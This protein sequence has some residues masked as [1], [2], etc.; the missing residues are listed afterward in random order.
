MIMQT[1]YKELLT[2]GISYDMARA[3]A[4]V[5]SFDFETI[6]NPDETRVWL[7]GAVNIHNEYFEYG[8][9]IDSFI[10]KYNKLD[11]KGYFHNLKFDIQFIFYWLLHHG[12]KHTAERRPRKGYFTTL[13][14][15]MGVFYSCQI[16]FFEGGTLTLYDSLRLMPMAV[17]D[18]PKA[19]GL[20]I[21]KLSIEYEAVRDI[22]HTP[23]KEEIDYVHHDCLIVARALNAMHQR[24]M[25]KLTAA[26]NA[27]N[28]FK[29]LFDKEEW[30]RL[31][32]QLPLS[33]DKDCRRAYKGGWTYLNPDY[34]DKILTTG[35][36]YDVNSMYPWAMSYTM[37]PWG[38]PVF[39]NG[40]YEEDKQMPLFI[41]CLSCR[42]KLKPGKYPSIQVKGSFRFLDTEYLVDSG[43][44][45]V[46]LYLTSVDYK[47]MMDNYE[48]W[49]I[50]YICGY[51]FRGMTGLF[52]EYVNYWYEQKN[53]SKHEKNYA[54]YY[55]AK[56]MLNSLYG[57]FGSNPEKRSKYPYLDEEEDIVKYE[58]GPVETGKTA[59]VPIAAFITSYCR[60]KII[61]TAIACGE[62]F[63]YA[64]TDSVHIIG[65]ETPDIDIDEYRLGAFKEE[66]TFDTAKFHRAKCYIEEINGEQEKKCAGLPAKARES[67]T[68]ETMEVGSVFKGKLVPKNIKGGVVL[69]ER[70]F[71]IK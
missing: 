61:R 58:Y 59:Y 46:L 29:K 11:C 16:K 66:S 4:P 17:A 7:W 40:K 43:E 25:T 5:Y 14:S 31:F 1:E 47:L 69:V 8:N 28:Q 57:K 64:D 2:T 56:L 22:N 20:D 23:T 19:F 38:E 63:I 48:V 34:K 50:E 44:E 53:Q 51:K 24:G 33:V 27:L 60:D 37:L 12:Y 49:D 35:K 32:P 55:I 65:D 10:Q 36:V 68:M 62:R 15:D 45:T 54:M 70:D 21:E 42:F 13:I 6:V 41:Q 30:N 18:M 3:T 39:Y 52:K 26:S 71:T 67:F 9:D